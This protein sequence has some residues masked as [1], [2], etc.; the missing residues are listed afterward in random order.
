MR[1]ADATTIPIAFITSVMAL[2]CIA[3]LE[4]GESVLIHS[5]S[6]AIGQACVKI[7]QHLGAEVFVTVDTLAS[8]RGTFGISSERILSSQSSELRGTTLGLTGAW[9]LL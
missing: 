1:S 7:A 8:L 6:G 3:R 9:T 2:V 5:V 4:K